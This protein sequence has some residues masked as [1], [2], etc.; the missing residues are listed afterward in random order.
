MRHRK[1][2]SPVEEGS[3]GDGRTKAKGRSAESRPTGGRAGLRILV[4][5]IN[6]AAHK[7][8]ALLRHLQPDLAIL[9]ECAAPDVIVAKC[10][11]F[12]FTDAQWQERSRHKGL[13]VFSFGNL[14][15]TRSPDYDPRFAVFLPLEVKGGQRFNLLAV[16]A[17]NFRV[18]SGGTM[19]DAL[20][21]YRRFLASTEAVV[22]G[23]FNNSVFWDRP[24]KPTNFA[25]I[26]AVLSE[27]GLASAYHTVTGE[28][29]AQE[30]QPTL[31]FL[32][33]PHQGY[34]IDYCFM[35]RAWFSRPVSVWVGQPGQWLAHSD[36]A[37]LVVA[38]LGQSPDSRQTR[39]PTVAAAPGYA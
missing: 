12:T 19:P 30:R 15:L 4:W 33:R 22:A 31:W 3:D 1:A 13:G 38:D 36:H 25:G 23:D 5:N 26:A 32:K 10:P 11:D 21:F 14:R 29:F 34:H 18:G 7:K 8:I 24:G 39:E 37:P 17:L 6:M 2:P 28:S 9:P 16:W 27:F 35:P 20:H